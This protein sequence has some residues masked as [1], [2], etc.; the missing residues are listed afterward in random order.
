M[1]DAAVMKPAY[2]NAMRQYGTGSDLQKAALAGNNLAGALASGAS[3]YLATEI[4]KLTTNPLTGE[5]DVAANTMAH[6]VLGAVTAQLNNQSVA[7]GGLGAGGGELAA[8]YIAGQ[9]FPGKTAQQLSES[10]KQQ[11]SALS[12]LAAGLAG[13]LATGDTAG[14][15]T[16]GQAGKNAVENNA[17]SDI[18]DAVSQGKTPQQV[19]EERVDAENERYK[20]QNCAGMSAEACSVKMYTERREELKDILST[21]ADFV[22]VVGD[23]K[24]F[25]EAQSALDYL[26]AAIGIIPGAGDAAGKAIKAAETA[27]KKGDVAEAS[28][29]LNKASSEISAHNAAT[30]PKLKEELKQQNLNN[31]AK[32]DPRLA[33]VVKGDNGKL[34]YGI[35]SGSKEEAD[36][37][38]KIWVGDGARPL[39][40][41]K[42]LISADG[43]RVYRYPAS[44]PNTPQE[45]SPTGVQA[46]FETLKDGQKTGNA[47]MV[48]TQ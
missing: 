25:A 16:G 18:V 34:N 5:V 9:L 21:G 11:V 41:G 42:G 35:G 12:Q 1:S 22:P 32:Q 2:D 36:R 46:N 6:A 14:A 44:K 40:D 31:I 26:V 3:P 28:K 33:A 20:Q 23:I 43:T 38:G 13:G 45:L 48:I 8:R 30:Y 24:S 7:A 29:Q 4:K 19:A 39:S 10:E 47:H 37:L 15:V 17:L 27:L